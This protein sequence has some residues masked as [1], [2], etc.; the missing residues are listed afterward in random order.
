[1]ASLCAGARPKNSASL[2]CQ[3][4]EIARGHVVADEA[5]QYTGQLVQ[6]PRSDRRKQSAL[7][8]SQKVITGTVEKVFGKVRLV[9][10]A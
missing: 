10:I 5:R 7:K 1:M 6:Q 2:R 9:F 4:P 3:R 8:Q